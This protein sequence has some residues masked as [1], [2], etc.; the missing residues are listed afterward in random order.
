[1]NKNFS[2]INITNLISMNQRNGNNWSKHKICFVLECSLVNT[3]LLTLK[4]SIFEL[5]D[6]SAKKINLGEGERHEVKKK[7]EKKRERQ[8]EKGRKERERK[9]KGR[10]KRKKTRGEIEK[11][12]FFF[13]L[14]PPPSLSLAFFSMIETKTSITSWL[15]LTCDCYCISKK[16]VGPFQFN[17][18]CLSTNTSMNA[19]KLYH[20]KTKNLYF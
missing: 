5:N 16:C 4:I 17:K 2:K 18:I 7:K 20:A 3:K 1:M 8:K 9:R 12:R 19:N 15:P 13:A 10:E 14:S 6:L 11:K